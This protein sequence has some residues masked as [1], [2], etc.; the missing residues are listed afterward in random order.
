MMIYVCSSERNALAN[1][2]KKQKKRIN[3]QIIIEKKDT[4]S[5]QEKNNCKT[6]NC[7]REDESTAGCF[8]RMQCVN[9][10]ALCTQ[11]LWLFFVGF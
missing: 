11:L 3:K 5:T 2:A 4:R 1:S 7:E 6:E 8:L 9:E 10:S